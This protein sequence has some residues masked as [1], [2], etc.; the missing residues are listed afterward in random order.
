MSKEEKQSE[1]VPPSEDLT[2]TTSPQQTGNSQNTE[3]PH[4]KSVA[5][6]LTFTAILVNLFLY[7]LDATKLAVETP[8]S[9]HP[10]SFSYVAIAEHCT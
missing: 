2:A 1:A 8:V 6:Y 10:L 5:F 3:K 4:K 9:T 7:A